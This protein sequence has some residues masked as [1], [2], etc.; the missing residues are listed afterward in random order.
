[1]E[2]KIALVGAIFVIEDP[3]KLFFDIKMNFQ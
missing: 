3:K 2:K 1:M